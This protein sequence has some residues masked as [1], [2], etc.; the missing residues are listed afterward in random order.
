MLPLLAPC[1]VVDLFGISCLAGLGEEMLFRG[2]V[3]DALAGQLPWWA[4]L[5]AAGALFGLLHAVTPAYAVLA[6]LMG[7]YLGWLYLYVGDL[8][9]PVVTH[10]LYDFA[11]LLWLLRGPDAPPAAEE[12]EEEDEGEQ[13]E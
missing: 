8:L 13:E 1:T 11:V 9:A 4:A 5:L 3:Q 6:A 12:E 2:V 10:A 7:V